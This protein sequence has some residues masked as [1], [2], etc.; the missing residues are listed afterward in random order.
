MLSSSANRIILLG[1]LT[2]IGQA[3]LATS[4]PSTAAPGDHESSVGRQ[5]TPLQSSKD[6][7]SKSTTASSAQSESA[8]A[9]KGKDSKDESK[10]RWA[11][12][13]SESI[14]TN[15]DKDD[16]ETQTL[17]SRNDS[18][19]E[20]SASK[21]QETDQSFSSN[22]AAY[23]KSQTPFNQE[24]GVKTTESTLRNLQED[25]QKTIHEAFSKASA[26]LEGN[27]KQATMKKPDN[28]KTDQVR[29]HSHHSVLKSNV[30][31]PESGLWN[32]GEGCKGLVR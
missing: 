20:K 25:I 13:A 22:N 15:K 14:Q 6:V 29:S 23:S 27:C 17:S 3:R 8:Q 12:A 11:S 30:F 9:S 16:T 21:K 10:L 2:K 5:G 19:A 32:K 4:V 1:R 26:G 31:H 18:G 28:V 7:N 24:S